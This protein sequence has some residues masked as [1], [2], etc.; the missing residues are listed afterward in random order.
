MNRIDAM[1]QPGEKVLWRL[2]QRARAGPIWAYL[3]AAGA[4]LTVIAVIATTILWHVRVPAGPLVLG[5]LL[6]LFP[7]FFIFLAWGGE[8]LPR[9]VAVTDHRILLA[10]SR[11]STCKE[12]ARAGILRVELFEAFG[13]VQLHLAGGTVRRLK[14]IENAE[15]FV[16]A[17]EVPGCIWRRRPQPATPV[18]ALLLRYSAYPITLGIVKFAKAAFASVTGAQPA[19]VIETTLF[20]FGSFGLCLAAAYVLFV[21]SHRLALRL[22]PAEEG[23]RYR[24][25]YLDRRCRGLRA[26]PACD[27]PV[28]M[29]LEDWFNTEFA[30]Q[31]FGGKV[32]CDC[33]PET[34]GPDA[35]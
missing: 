21:T 32:D 1:L 28:W 17:L 5:G 26:Y 34:I 6:M 10:G 13:S 30:R 29:R 2:D 25:W 31:A 16:R 22:L 7:L 24:C 14:G 15:S 3:L 4:P 8:W 20:I 9:A 33:A 19:G 27:R 18:S 11:P 23:L 12:I 35:P